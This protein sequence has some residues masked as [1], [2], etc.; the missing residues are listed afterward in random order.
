[1]TEGNNHKSVT[2]KQSKAQIHI[3]ER[4]CKFFSKASRIIGTPDFNQSC[5][6]NQMLL[7][8]INMHHIMANIKV[9][10]NIELS[11]C[12]F[13][14]FGILSNMRNMIKHRKTYGLCIKIELCYECYRSYCGWFLDIIKYL[15]DAFCE[16]SSI[17]K[18]YIIFVA[19]WVKNGLSVW[20]PEVSTPIL[21]WCIECHQYQTK[22]RINPFPRRVS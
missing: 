18:Y 4:I 10:S 19:L 6:R 3:Y 17:V 7:N 20:K 2:F 21:K 5:S 13:T 1:M 22:A 11:C 16:F 14:D 9:W 12:M 15:R 8:D